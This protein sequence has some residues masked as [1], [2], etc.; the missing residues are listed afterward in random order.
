MLGFFRIF[1][2]SLGAFGT[3][4]GSLRFVRI[5]SS[6]PGFIRIFQIPFHSV[7]IVFRIF[8][9]FGIFSG[10]SRVFGIVFRIFQDLGIKTVLGIRQDRRIHPK[11]P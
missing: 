10:F 11:N 1:Q 9:I 3:P 6:D 7:D 5:P 2:P 8:G 4:P